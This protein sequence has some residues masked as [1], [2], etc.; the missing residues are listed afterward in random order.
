ML[1]TCTSPAVLS[2]SLIVLFLYAPTAPIH[3]AMLTAG[4]TLG[5]RGFDLLLPVLAGQALVAAYV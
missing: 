3:M 1:G 4:L 5:R 2:P